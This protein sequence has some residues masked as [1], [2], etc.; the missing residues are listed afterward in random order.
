MGPNFLVKRQWIRW[1]N[2]FK[3][4]G[5]MAS[6]Y[7]VKWGR[8]RWPNRLKFQWWSI[9]TCTIASSKCPPTGLKPN[10]LQSIWIIWPRLLYFDKLPK[11]EGKLW[12][13]WIF[14]PWSRLVLQQLTISLRFCKIFQ[15]IIHIFLSKPFLVD[16]T[17]ANKTM[18]SS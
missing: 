11:K 13:F 14:T 17:V 10:Y 2:E 12:R 5:K 4:C 6:K 9:Q 15:R 18:L 1:P 8:I 3:L 7:L 16:L